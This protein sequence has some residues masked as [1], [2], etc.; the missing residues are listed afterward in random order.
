[1][2]KGKYEETLTGTPQGGNLSPL[3]SNIMLNE[4][5]KEL[6]ARGLKFTRYADDC[7]IVV[8]SSAAAKR[9]MYSITDWIERK[10][11]LKVNAEKTCIT[12]PTNLK[13]L[14]FG[15]WKDKEGIWRA[16]PHQKSVAKFKR[17]LKKLCCRSWSVDMDYRL[18]KLNEVIRGWINYFAMGD[19]KKTMQTTDEHLR[20]MMRMIIW[21]QWKV[22]SKRK[23]G[24]QKLGIPEW[25]ASKTAYWGN[26]YILVA[27]KSCL[28]RAV[29]KEIL[30]KRGLVSCLD[31]YM[32][33]HALKLNRT[34]GC[35]TARPVV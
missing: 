12:K 4:L 33:Q 8:G 31:Y 2:V 5:D 17:K 20:T 27:T 16:R 7:V 22:P 15:F 23:W 30:T 13:Y 26:C 6:E 25:L 19:M 1:M 14:G 10:L 3:L 28:S 24:L 35:R 21:K 29:S 18:K 9:V 32:N 34:A 11:G